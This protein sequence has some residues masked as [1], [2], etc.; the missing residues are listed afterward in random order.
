MLIA[1]LTAYLLIHFGSHTSAL[2]DEWN[3]TMALV[4]QNVSDETRQKRALAIVA[5]MKATST[6]FARQRQ[7]SID[8]LNKLMTPR[9][10]PASD[11]QQAVQPLISEDLASANKLL[12]LRFQLKSVLTAGEWAL[13]FPGPAKS[14]DGAQKSS[15]AQARIRSELGA[16]PP[17]LRA[18]Y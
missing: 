8:A 17:A 2:T 9:L 10:V 1:A 12:D 4:K 3:Q 6:A 11:I 16:P 18:T 14:L 13:V 5:D 15:Q 7:N